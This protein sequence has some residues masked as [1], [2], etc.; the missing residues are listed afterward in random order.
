[1][2]A[3][4]CMI[5]EKT[6]FFFDLDGTLVD[7]NEANFLA[8]KAAIA[9]VKSI[10][11]PQKWFAPEERVHRENLKTWLPDLSDKDIESIVAYKEQCYN[12]FLCTTKLIKSTVEILMRYSNTHQMVL[13]SKGRKDRITEILKFHNLEDKFTHLFFRND[14]AFGQTSNKFQHAIDCL[15]ISPNNIIAFE[16]ESMEILDAQTANIRIINPNT[17]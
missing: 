14:F 11:I 4:R 10:E 2:N 16:N 6:V 5:S 13:V 9:A 12:T 8:Y 17:L 1:M 7:T 3:S 15:G